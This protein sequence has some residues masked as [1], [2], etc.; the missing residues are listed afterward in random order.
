MVR[1]RQPSA[2]RSRAAARGLTS[3]LGLGACASAPDY[4]PDTIAPAAGLDPDVAAVTDGSWYRPAREVTWQWQIQGTI[5]PAY[6]VEL[7]DIDLFDAPDSAIDELHAAGRKVICYFS[8]GS[9]EEF[10]DDYGRFAANDLA[11]PLDGWPGERWVDIRSANVVEI[12]D[13]RIALAAERG[14]DGVEPDNVAAFDE[15][16]G[17][18]LT[19]RDQLAFNRHLAN[20]AHELGLSVALKNDGNQAEALVEYFD[21]ELNEECHQYDE[22]AP[23]QP[24]LEAGKPVL[25]TEYADSASAAEALAQTLCPKA[26]AAGT[27]TLVLHLDLDDKFRVACP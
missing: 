15:D 21:F 6:D 2:R 26:V 5:N 20:R 11:K 13:G 4:V 3:L 24:F 14:C 1:F 9:A 25:N 8:A 17:F 27:R 16:T 7:Y 10:R 18:A 22:C 19:A 12:M 23:L